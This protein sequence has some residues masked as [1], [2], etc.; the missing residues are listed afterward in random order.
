MKSKSLYGDDEQLQQTIMGRL[1]KSP[2]ESSRLGWYPLDEK[3]ICIAFFL[4]QHLQFMNNGGQD[5]D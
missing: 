1:R 5:H 2:E 3:T 4:D